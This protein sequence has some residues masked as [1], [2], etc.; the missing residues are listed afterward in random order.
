[1][2]A[3]RQK[4]Y[5]NLLSWGGSETWWRRYK[6]HWVWFAVV[7]P[8]CLAEIIVWSVVS[9]SESSAG[10]CICSESLFLKVQRDSY[11]E[12]HFTLTPLT[13]LGYSMFTFLCLQLLL[14]LCL[15]SSTLLSGMGRWRASLEPIREEQRYN[16]PMEKY[17][18]SYC[19]R[20]QVLAASIGQG[21]LHFKTQDYIPD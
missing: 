10:G 14:A 20:C 13:P 3:G 5:L 7:N 11:K 16:C 2:W 17:T 6:E 18:R 4:G 8:P 15:S 12:I 19:K 21:R 1:M 9:Q